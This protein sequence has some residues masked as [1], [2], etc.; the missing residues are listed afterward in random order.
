MTGH[1]ENHAAMLF[2]G[3]SYY[4]ARMGYLAS[5]SRFSI[6]FRCM[7]SIV[8]KQRRSSSEGIDEKLPVIYEGA[9]LFL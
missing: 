4:S 1:P 6:C 8:Y 5:E 3:L 2:C 9:A 7:A